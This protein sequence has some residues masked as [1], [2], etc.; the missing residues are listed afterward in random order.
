VLYL[1]ALV[2][3]YNSMLTQESELKT[4]GKRFSDKEKV[5]ILQIA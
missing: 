4:K 2:C 5:V 1:Y 3:Y